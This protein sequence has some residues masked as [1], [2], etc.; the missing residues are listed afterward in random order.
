MMHLVGFIV[1][2]VFRQY[3]L[4]RKMMMFGKTAIRNRNKII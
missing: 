4:T 3:I 1:R 2:E